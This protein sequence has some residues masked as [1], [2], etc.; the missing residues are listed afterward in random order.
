MSTIFEEAKKL[1]EELVG[2]RRSIHQCPEVVPSLPKTK[3]FGM[4]K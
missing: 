3:A 4:D 2:I 1:Q